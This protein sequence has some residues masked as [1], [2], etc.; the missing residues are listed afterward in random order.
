MNIKDA[1]KSIIRSHD[2]DRLAP[3]TT[4]WGEDLTRKISDSREHASTSGSLAGHV[5][6]EYP[7]P[8]FQRD[9]FLSLNGFWDYAITDTDTVPD[10]F[11]GQILVPFS[12]ECT[13]SGVNRQLLPSQYL[14]Y[15]RS[16]SHLPGQNPG[17]ASSLRTI[18]HFGAVDYRA[19]VYVNGRLAA[20]HRGG[21][22]PFQVDITG[23]LK[24]NLP[25][26]DAPAG[27]SWAEGKTSFWS[28]LRIPRSRAVSP[29]ESS[30]FTGAASFILP[31][32]GSGRRYGWSR[33]PLP[34]LKRCGS[35]QI[36]T[37]AG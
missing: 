20:T 26:Q 29:E 17:T 18:L 12:P 32:A 36:M 7:R 37:T 8:Q 2:K 13:L 9:S 22:L 10:S 25:A 24:G 19:Q 14:W 31:R 33:F 4:V 3:L 5:L 28:E 23:F 15:R 6:P 16:L 35:R 30:P 11:D 27:D 21:Y 34:T 1:V